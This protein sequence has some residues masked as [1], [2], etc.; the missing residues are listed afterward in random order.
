MVRPKTRKTSY[1]FAAL[2]QAGKNKKMK[3][4]SMSRQKEGK[5]CSRAFTLYSSEIIL[6]FAATAAR[7]PYPRAILVEP[8][9]CSCFGSNLLQLSDRDAASA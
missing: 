5:K 9:L 4:A 3:S 1:G 6:Y 7:A 2:P 8:N